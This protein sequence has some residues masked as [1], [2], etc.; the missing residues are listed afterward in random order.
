MTG[1]VV[2]ALSV[3]GLGALLGGWVLFQ[4]WIAR[5][6]PGAPGVEGRKGCGGGCARHAPRTAS[7]DAGAPPRA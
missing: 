5:H 6:D 3:L 2:P 7:R 4:G 1:F